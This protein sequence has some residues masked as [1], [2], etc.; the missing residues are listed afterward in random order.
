MFIFK[1]NS[2]LINKYSHNLKSIVNIHKI[3]IKIIESLAKYVKIYFETTSHK[4]K[5]IK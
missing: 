5:T 4:S 3:S 2:S 1:N